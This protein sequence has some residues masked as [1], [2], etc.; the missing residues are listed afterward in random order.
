MTLP[1]CNGEYGQVH[2]LHHGQESYL[3]RRGGDGQMTQGGSNSDG[4][5]TSTTVLQANFEA[6][7]RDINMG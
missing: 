1:G 3:C 7:L 2:L 5:S 4:G 6:R